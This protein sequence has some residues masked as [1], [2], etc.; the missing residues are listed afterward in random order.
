MKRTGIK[1]I[2]KRARVSLASVSRFLN[3]GDNFSIRESTKRRIRKAV[4]ELNYI[5]D[6]AARSLKSGKRETIGVILSH[7]DAH[8]TGLLA[9]VEICLSRKKHMLL[10]ASSEHNV[11]HECALINAMRR[12]TDALLIV[13]QYDGSTSMDT[14]RAALANIPA[15]FIDSDPAFP[16]AVSVTGDNKGDAVKAVKHFADRGVR[17]F[18]YQGAGR[19]LPVLKSRYEGFC[20]ALPHGAAQEKY[21][22]IDNADTQ[23]FIAR[24]KAAKTPPLMFF[25]SLLH[26]EPYLSACSEHGIVVGRDVFITGFDEPIIANPTETIRKIAASL[27]SPIPFI[28]QDRRTIAE[29]SV[30]A[31]L[32]GAHVSERVPG[33][34]MNF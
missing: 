23:R 7:I 19:S 21:E 29:K 1:E 33:I 20:E 34:F 30:D 8:M 5:P 3:N 18:I 25:A 4:S 9:E 17:E 27:A 13:S 24:I 32:S 26:C 31:A 2:A 11:V 22:D 16:D 12:R 28:L 10:L 6:H 14:Y 15:V